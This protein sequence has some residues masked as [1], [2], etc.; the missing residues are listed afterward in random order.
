MQNISSPPQPDYDDPKELYAFFG[1]AFYK[2]NILEQGVVNLAV[3]LMAQGNLGVTVGDVNRL[4]DSFD[5]KTFGPVLRIAKER[6]SFTSEF[7]KKLDQA[8]SYR[9]YL[10][11]GF[12]KQHDINHMSEDGR[13]IMIDELIEIWMH[14][15]EADR[16][17]DEYWMSA[18][19]ANGITK[20]WIAKQMNTYVDTTR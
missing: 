5:T 18:W 15:A 6:Y 13:K 12:F 11:H 7:S 20:E 17:I 19:E 4:Y 2:A 1:L 3:A 10:A 16:I 9:N 8:L 14:L